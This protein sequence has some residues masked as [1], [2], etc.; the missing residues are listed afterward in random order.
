MS[1]ISARDERFMRVALALAE[2]ELGRTW[3]NPSVGCVIVREGR[4]VG[5][6]WTRRGGRPHAETEAL[7]RAGEAARG[8]EAYVT[9]EPCNHTGHT[10][11]CTRAFLAAGIRRV[12]VG[13]IDPDPRVDGRGI[14]E[15]RAAGVEV[16]VGC[17]EA[18]ARAQNLGLYRRI[19]DGRPMV[20]LKLALT[21][22]GRIAT[23]RGDSRWISGER[24]R[25][26]AHRL[27]ACHDAVA[28]GSGTALADD[29]ELTCRLPGLED[30]QPVRVVF[31]RRLRLSPD[32]TL[33]RTVERGPVW[34]LTRPDAD[35]RRRAAL[36][37]R[38]V[39]V[40][41]VDG[42][43]LRAALA[44]LA[45]RGLTRL[46]VE[47]GGTLAAAL[48]L[49]GVVDRLHLVHAPLVFGAEAVAAVGAL[50]LDRVGEAPRFRVVEEA[51]LGEDRLLVLE[52]AEETGTVGCSPGS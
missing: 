13:C 45:R 18:E 48:L 23:R 17:L 8:A 35:P 1:G 44:L 29:P 52:P 42:P 22:D 39:E 16:A 31:D 3:P 14:A 47:G 34:V 19:R 4:I 10:P 32:S 49:E 33:A 41:A 38:G 37:A 51:R 21:L 36:E 50:G 2:R 6:G 27:R 11:P 20:A 26:E 43:F 40:M 25:T 28:V 46:L 12:V 30:S 7:A 5:R 24:A 9:L 15:L